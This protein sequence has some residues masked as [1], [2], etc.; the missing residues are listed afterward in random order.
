[1]PLTNWLDRLAPSSRLAYRRK[2][3]LGRGLCF[4]LQELREL[5]LPGQR[6]RQRI[7][8]PCSTSHEKRNDKTRKEEGTKLRQVTD[9][10]LRSKTHCSCSPSAVWPRAS[11]ASSRTWRGAP[12]RASAH[13]GVNGSGPYGIEDGLLRL[14]DALLHLERMKRDLIPQQVRRS[15]AMPA[16]QVKITRDVGVLGLPVVV[17]DDMLNLEV[18]ELILKALCTDHFLALVVFEPAVILIFPPEFATALVTSLA[19][20]S[21]WLP[22]SDPS[23]P[24][25]F[26]CNITVATSTSMSC[27]AFLDVAVDRSICSFAWLSTSPWRSSFLQSRQDRKE[28]RRRRRRRIIVPLHVVGSDDGKVVTATLLDR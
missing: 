26:H 20:A 27:L 9:P 1:M 19:S 2:T 23:A 12:A 5:S 3:I 11:A 6:L 8:S 25:V 18:S 15:P 7:L 17:V 10:T 28:R 22:D 4:L 24:E 21:C 14:L 13:G 16:C